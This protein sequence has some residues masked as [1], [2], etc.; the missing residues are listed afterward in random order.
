MQITKEDTGALTAMIKLQIS[1]EDYEEK[2][3]KR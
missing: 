3:M 2:V 1:Q